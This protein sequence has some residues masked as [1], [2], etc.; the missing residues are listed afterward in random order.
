MNTNLLKFAEV[1]ENLSSIESFLWDGSP[2]ESPSAQ[3]PSQV[4]QP[5]Q[6]SFPEPSAGNV[7]L[8]QR[9][10]SMISQLIPEFQPQVA[11][12]MRRGLAAGLRPEITEGYRAQER[13]EALYEQGRSKPGP[14][15][16]WTKESMHTKRMAVDIA[17]LDE[18]GKITYKTTPGF[19][20]Q[21]GE[22]GKSLGMNWG[23]DWKK[24][25]DLPH[26]QYKPKSSA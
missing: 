26:F 6:K 25:K 21:M 11:E 20:E 15:V 18:N 17:Q 3:K 16:T 1:F 4:P 13:Q 14:I 9:T 8:S 10:Q 22:I 5:V 24:N 12:L 7:E 2:P 23:G 19:W